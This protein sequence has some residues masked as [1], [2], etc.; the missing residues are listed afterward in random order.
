[1]KKIVIIL[2]V[3]ILIGIGY[4]SLNN[5]TANK[6]TIVH[7]S[8]EYSER[9]DTGEEEVKDNQGEIMKDIIQEVQSYDEVN[10]NGEWRRTQQHHEGTLIISTFNGDTFMMSL[11]VMNGGNTGGM[12]GSATVEG[13]TATFVD[14]ELGTGCIIKMTLKNDVIT[15]EE[16]EECLLV[17]GMGTYFSGEYVNILSE[18]FETGTHT[19]SSK[20]IIAEEHD[21]TIQKLL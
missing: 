16:T 12:E 1:M 6:T 17:G 4:F 20:G 9:N 8:E 21:E 13:N 15:I 10:W 19:L 14:G 2:S 3:L 7:N 11:D 5:I 18:S